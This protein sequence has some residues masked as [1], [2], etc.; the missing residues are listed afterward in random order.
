[1]EL[2]KFILLS[3]A[4]LFVIIDPIATVPV[5]LAM[6]PM[7]KRANRFRPTEMPNAVPMR[8]RKTVPAAE[9]RYGGDGGQ[10]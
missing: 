4:S 3:G 1:M 6:T 9:R 5:F 8:N 10:E 2:L 7:T